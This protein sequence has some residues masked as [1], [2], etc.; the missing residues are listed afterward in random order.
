MA[1][2]NLYG[3]MTLNDVIITVSA[4]I[5]GGKRT[6]SGGA[7]QAYL[8]IHRDDLQPFT[9]VEAIMVAAAGADWGEY[10]SIL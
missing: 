4:L 10:I 7:L 6:R 2:R 5:S 3:Q 1:A 9:D 8:P